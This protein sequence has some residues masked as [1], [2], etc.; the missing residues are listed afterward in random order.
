MLLQE[1]QAAR[2]HPAGEG[3]V[4]VREGTYCRAREEASS[5]HTASVPIAQAYPAVVSRGSP[6][7]QRVYCE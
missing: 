3:L 2:G 4:M 1:G 6:A 5:G 7:N